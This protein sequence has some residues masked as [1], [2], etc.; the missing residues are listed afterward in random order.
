MAPRWS[1]HDALSE[2]DEEG[3]DATGEEG[4]PSQYRLEDIGKYEE[5]SN[6][7]D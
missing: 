1:R 2:W 6:R 7:E 4:N 3:D 5:R